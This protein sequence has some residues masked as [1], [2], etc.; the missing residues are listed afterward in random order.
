VFWLSDLGDCNVGSEEGVFVWARGS[1]LAFGRLLL[2]SDSEPSSRGE[3]FKYISGSRGIGEDDAMQSL[4]VHKL[5]FMH[6]R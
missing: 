4:R 5:T 6:V 2:T 3:S 1:R